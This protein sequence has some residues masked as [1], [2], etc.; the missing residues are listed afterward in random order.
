MDSKRKSDASI[1]VEQSQNTSWIAEEDNHL[2][3]SNAQ[4]LLNSMKDQALFNIDKD[5]FVTSWNN[6]ARNLTGY[7]DSEI[8]GK[9]FSIFYASKDASAGLPAR[10]LEIARQTGRF[11]EDGLRV[12]K[13]SEQYWAHVIILAQYDDFGD[14]VGFLNFR[15]DISTF[16][17][18]KSDLSKSEQ[19]FTSFFSNSL[20]AMILYPKEAGAA[21]FNCAFLSLV[22]YS[23]DE[24]SNGDLYK[25]LTP[26]EFIELDRVRMEFVERE[27]RPT[28]YEKEF[29]SKNGKKVPV[30]VTLF[31]VL[32]EEKVLDRIGAIIRDLRRD[33]QVI[34]ELE[35]AKDEAIKFGMAKTSFL[36]NMTH[37]IRT[38]LNGIIGMTSLLSEV[39]V[40]KEA[41][42]YIDTIRASGEHLLSIVN[43]ILDFSRIESGQMALEKIEFSPRA[44]VEETFALFTAE[45]QR[46]GISLSCYVPNNVP[47][48]LTGDPTKLRQILFN[49]LSNALKFT[50]SG[51]VDMAVRVLNADR[52]SVNLSFEIADTG[53]GITDAGLKKLFTPFVQADNSTTRVYGGTGLGLSITK[54]LAEIM[55][56]NI[57][58]STV[59][60]EGSTFCLEIRLKVAKSVVMFPR[61]NLDGRR[62]LWKGGSAKLESQLG[63]YL[64]NRGMLFEDALASDL[65]EEL[66]PGAE[67]FVMEEVNGR[68][69]VSFSNRNSSLNLPF[70]QSDL[71]KTLAKL[72]TPEDL[73]NE[74]ALSVSKGASSY[75]ANEFTNKRVLIVDDNH[76]NR[77]VVVRMLEKMGLNSD[78]ACNGLEAVEA[79]KNGK[80]S[81]VLMDCLMPVMDGF[82]A[83]K[84]I[85]K[86]ASSVN[87]PII[88]MT[89]NSQR[90]SEKACQEAGMDDFLEKPMHLE[91]LLGLLRKYLPSNHKALVQA[92]S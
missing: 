75:A 45:S 25:Q 35:K 77:L 70:K 68:L 74:T 20:D 59:Y 38:P 43:E 58:V 65:H 6:G 82:T 9:H 71:Y 73:Q 91:D 62:V 7:Q 23:I 5:G 19:A 53:I 30:A 81:L 17:K 31:P 10:H 27:L 33:K 15:R 79:V 78:I 84:E 3:I 13:N 12:K 8:L 21:K 85:R 64:S 1:E 55:G 51:G 39:D 57:R 22:G 67:Q 56:G 16:K 76:I 40:S 36:A 88:A 42:E 86:L 49:L 48:M 41:R 4:L 61:A 80:Y 46:R 54:K 69:T 92:V 83:T 26:A 34:R 32:S 87:M 28:R 14:I 2:D 18:T 52:D 72:I 89:A 60:G 44:L 37:E 11:E 47:F 66:Q 29:L 90:S 50:S 24:L 63:K